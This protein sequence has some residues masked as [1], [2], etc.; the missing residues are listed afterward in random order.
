MH[1]I[2]IASLLASSAF[3]GKPAPAPT[4]PAKYDASQYAGLKDYE[5]KR[6]DRYVTELQLMI[7]RQQHGAQPWQVQ[8]M[9]KRREQIDQEFERFCIKA[10]AK[11]VR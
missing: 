7:K 9:N 11:L 1:R 3:A 10:A 4:L 6:C 2:L 5:I 8:Q